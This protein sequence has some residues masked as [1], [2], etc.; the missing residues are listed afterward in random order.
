[1]IVFIHCPH[2]LAQWLGVTVCGQ[3][4]SLCRLFTPEP[5]EVGLCQALELIEALA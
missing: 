5:G 1:M 2:H 3:W 4:L